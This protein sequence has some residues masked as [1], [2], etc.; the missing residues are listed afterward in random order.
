MAT[1]RVRHQHHANVQPQHVAVAGDGRR[2]CRGKPRGGG[3]YGEEW[4]Q[5]GIKLN[6]QNVFND[7]IAAGEWLVTNCYTRPAKLAI[8]GRSNGGLLVGAVLTQRPDLFGAAL[9]GVGV[10]DMLRF[11]K[12]TIGWAWT[13]DWRL[14]GRSGG[15]QGASHAYSPLHNIQPGR[16]MPILPDTSSPRA[17]TTTAWFRRMKPKFAATL[18]SAQAQAGGKPVLIRIGKPGPATAQENL[19]TTKL[20]G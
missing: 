8:E 5:G 12:F 19:I 16:E 20:I 1:V 4:H 13:S 17:I 7:Y 2:L 18:Q 11:H 15:V 3:E 6:K 9:L 10:M 14:G